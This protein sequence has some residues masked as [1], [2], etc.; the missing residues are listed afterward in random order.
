MAPSTT[1]ARYATCDKGL[2][3]YMVTPQS[4]SI[5]SSSGLIVRLYL[6]ISLSSSLATTTISSVCF[7]QAA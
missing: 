6:T 1:S 2:K 5:D 4:L 7:T 3:R